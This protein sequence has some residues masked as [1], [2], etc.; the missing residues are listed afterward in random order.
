MTRILIYSDRGGLGGAEQ[1]NHRLALALH[2]AGLTVAVAEPD[3]TDGLKTQRMALG[4]AH[5]SLPMEDI[6]DWEHPAP[7]LTDPGPAERVL[8]TVRPDLVLFAD[9]FPLA[10]L[11]AKQA[12]ARRGLAYLVLV[13]CVQ[14]D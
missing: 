3:E 11:T 2:Q 4:I 14:P 10:N 5:M 6:Y 13:H 12:A 9:S 1:I 8:D 7:S